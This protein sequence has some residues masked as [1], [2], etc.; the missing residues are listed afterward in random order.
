VAAC[1]SLVL[2]WVPFRLLV[3]GVGLGLY[4]RIYVKRAELRERE[5]AKLAAQ[6]TNPPPVN[7]SASKEGEDAEMETEVE[8]ELNIL[9]FDWTDWI[10]PRK[11]F[12]NLISHVFARTP[13]Y[14]EMVHRELAR[15]HALPAKA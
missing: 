3:W 7:R 11:V 12:P 9:D 4:S 2:Y 13:D 1:T 6:G 10:D 5:A 15:S 8:R 14:M